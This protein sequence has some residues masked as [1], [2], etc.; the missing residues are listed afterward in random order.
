VRVGISLFPRKK[1]QEEPAA[2]T[3][4]APAAPPTKVEGPERLTA[5][6]WAKK[7]NFNE[8]AAE[9]AAMRA[10]KWHDLFT[11]Q[12]FLDLIRTASV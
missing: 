7:L 5:N 2:S 1:K 10:G 3:A 8:V 4:A 9:R 6:D 11:E 12:E